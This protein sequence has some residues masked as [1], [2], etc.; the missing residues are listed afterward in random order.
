MF[1]FGDLI[2][3]P[4]ITSLGWFCTGGYHILG[5]SLRMHVYFGTAVGLASSNYPESRAGHSVVT[6]RA[7]HVVQV[8]GEVSHK[9]D[10]LAL[11]VGGWAWSLKLYTLK[12]LTAETL[13]TVEAGRKHL[14]RRPDKNKELRIYNN[15]NIYLLQLGC[16]PVAVVILHVNKT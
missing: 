10:N 14:K 11:Q 15:N 9:R 13:L 7:F 8:K 3:S 2:M 12:F 6:G 1:R 4:F 5:S 16:Y